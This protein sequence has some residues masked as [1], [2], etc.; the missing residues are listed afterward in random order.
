[1]AFINEYISKEDI[2]KYDIFGIRNK[3]LTGSY[4][5]TKEREKH[6]NLTW[7]INR[8]RKIWFC[9]AGRVIDQDLDF[10][11][12]TGEE[13]WYLNYKGTNLEVRLQRGKESFTIKE[14][15]YIKHWIFLSVTPEFLDDVSNKE[16]KNI[17]KE[18]LDVYGTRGMSS[19][20]D[21]KNI[22]LTF[23]NF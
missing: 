20:V 9:Y 1:M 10:G 8:E 17:I 4:Q 2:E 23:E 22:E 11:Q 14:R 7:V 12:G 15:P 16:L 18:A 3:F 21:R 5:I 19:Q 6:F 13:I